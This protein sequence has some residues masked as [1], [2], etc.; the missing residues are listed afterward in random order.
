MSWFTK[1]PQ[2]LVSADLLGQLEAFGRVAW[3]SKVNTAPI[4][5]P[6]FIWEGFFAKFF[7]ASQADLDGAITE[8]HGAAGDEP[9]ARYGGYRLV[10]EFEPASQHPLYL[11]MMDAGLQMMYDAGLSSMYLTGYERDRWVAVHGD[12]RSSFDRIVEVEPAPADAVADIALAP[13]QALMVASMGAGSL[14]NQFWIERRGE[15][16]Y[17]AFSMRQQN[18]ESVA[19]SRCEEAEVG[20]SESVEGVLRSLAAYLRIPPSWVHPELDPFFTQRRAL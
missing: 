4:T 12:V 18:S 1:R 7:P 17:G 16:T 13:G 2:T 19:L 5:D 10:A 6:R 20:T 15:T 11:D 9:F 8:V 3:Q 14:D